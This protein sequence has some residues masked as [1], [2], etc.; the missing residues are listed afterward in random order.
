MKMLDFDRALDTARRA[1]EAAGRAAL[2]YFRTGVRVDRKPDRSPVT[3]A[4]RAAE[5]A[6]LEIVRAAFPDASILAE[7][8]GADDRRRYAGIVDPLD[9]TRGFTRGGT[10]WGPLVALEHD[11]EIVAGG[12]ALPALGELYFA[13]RPRLPSRR[14]HS[15]PAV[16]RRRLDRSDAEHRRTAAT[17]GNAAGERRTPAH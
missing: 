1:V 3:A 7:E 10:F 4:D 2:P 12:A 14:R 13:A 5:A 6:I 8:N 11:G 17:P 9:G 16:V 15:G